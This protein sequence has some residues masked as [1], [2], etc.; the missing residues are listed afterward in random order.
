GECLVYGARP[1]A[2]RKQ[3]ALD[4]QQCKDAFDQE[5]AR[6][7]AASAAPPVEGLTIEQAKL[8]IKA[9]MQVF[10]A[11]RAA[12]AAAGVDDAAYEFQEALHIALSRPDAF[13]A[14]LAGEAIF[15]SAL[16]NR[17]VN[18]EDVARG[19]VQVHAKPG[20]A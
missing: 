13:E 14:W 15:D 10:A 16:A 8:P 3:H 11:Y 5:A 18:V 19:L 6:S 17:E 20:T 9:G 4:A 7:D 2:C 12:L 1:L